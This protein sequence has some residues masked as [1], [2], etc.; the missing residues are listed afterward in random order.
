MVRLLVC[1]SDK[2]WP[3]WEGLVST[4]NPHR[5]LCSWPKYPFRGFRP[6]KLCSNAY[7]ISSTACPRSYRPP[8]LYTSWVRDEYSRIFYVGTHRGGARDRSKTLDVTPVTFRQLSTNHL[9]PCDV[10]LYKGFFYDFHHALSYIPPRVI[11]HSCDVAWITYMLL[12]LPVVI[13]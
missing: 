4:P 10:P 5:R 6:S 11:H 13:C 12:A 9:S 2:S 1:G 8:S 3:T 7:G